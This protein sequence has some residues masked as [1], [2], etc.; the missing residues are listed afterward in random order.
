MKTVIG[1]ILGFVCI[2]VGDLA[3][4]FAPAPTDTSVSEGVRLGFDVAGELKEAGVYI[5]VLAAIAGLVLREGVKEGLAPAIKEGFAELDKPVR[6]GFER[7]LQHLPAVFRE[8]I[9]PRR[10]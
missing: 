2:G 6:E 3:H 1:I 9:K 5:L 4:R 10:S 8:W 7:A